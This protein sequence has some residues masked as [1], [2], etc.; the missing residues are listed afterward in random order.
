MEPAGRRSG[1]V[2]VGLA[3]A[4]PPLGGHRR[5]NDAAARKISSLDRGAFRADPSSQRDL[6]ST[7]SRRIDAS[8]KPYFR[9][10][11][12]RTFGSTPAAATVSRRAA[13]ALAMGSGSVP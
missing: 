7:M 13:W 5:R 11:L 8:G 12:M 3:V 1:L 9:S 2:A 4:A 6:F 10:R